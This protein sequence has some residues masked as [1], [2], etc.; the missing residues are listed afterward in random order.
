MIPDDDSFWKIAE[1]QGITVRRGFSSAY[2]RSKQDDAYLI[3]D[4]AATVC[5]R[6]KSSTI[7]LEA[8]DADYVPPLKKALEKGWRTEV[9]FVARGVST[10]LTPL[11]HQ[12]RIIQ[13]SDI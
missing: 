7:V 9:A 11:V 5:E 10:Y 3:T 1:N 13:P 2:R 8:C 12:F 6:P 4:L